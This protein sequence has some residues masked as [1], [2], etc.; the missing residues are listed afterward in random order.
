MDRL[1]ELIKLR[2]TQFERLARVLAGQLPLM[3]APDQ[4]I[5]HLLMDAYLDGCRDIRDW[6]ADALDDA[7]ATRLPGDANGRRPT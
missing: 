1:D 5:A 2:E 6:I 4:L 7:P 3:T